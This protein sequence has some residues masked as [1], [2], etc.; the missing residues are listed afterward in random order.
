MVFRAWKKLDQQGIA[1]KT[2][3]IVIALL[4]FLNLML[5]LFLATAPD[6]MRVYLPP[7][8]TQGA[9]IS[10]HHVPKATVYA[11]AFQIFTA[12]NSW[13]GDGTQAYGANIRHY[14]HY[15]SGSFYHTLQQDNLARQT[16]GELSRQRIMSAVSGMGYQ[17]TD[18]TVLGNG[19]WKVMLHLQI[20]ETLDG[21]VIKRVIMSYP[22]LINHVNTSIQVNPWGLVIGGFSASPYRIKTEA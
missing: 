13:D 6:R 10:P 5:M 21:A 12:I 8:L 4:V 2:L 18:V 14:H 22:L 9:T 11:F 20:V 19:A 7:D 3:W 15:L 1:I 16:N 17:P